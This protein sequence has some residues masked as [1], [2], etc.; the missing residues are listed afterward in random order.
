M[1]KIGIDFGT[2]FCSA[3]WINPGT[4]K[5]EAITFLDTEGDP[6]KMPSIVYYAENGN[7][8]VGQAAYNILEDLSRISEEEEQ[9]NAI[10]ASIFTSI[11]RK[12]AREG[13]R[14][15]RGRDVT[16]QTVIKDILLKIKTEAEK[17]PFHGTIDEAVITHPVVFD[18]W[19]KEMLHSAAVEAGFQHVELFPEPVAAA[20]GHMESTGQWSHGIL[21]YDFGGGTFDVAYIARRHDGSYD[22]PLI[23]EG[24][25][26]CGGDDIDDLLYEELDKCANQRYQR[27]ITPNSY[28]RD[29][30]FLSRC[31]KQK[32][33]MSIAIKNGAPLQPMREILPPPGF[34]RIEMT[35]DK[36]QFE[37]IISPVIEKTI[38]KTQI[39]L[40]RIRANGLPLETAILIGGS[41]RIPMIYD[42]LAEI[43]HPIVPEKVMDVDVAVALGAVSDR[44]KMPSTC[45]CIHCEREIKSTYKYC[46]YC[47]RD[48][49][50]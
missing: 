41:S 7:V 10:L 11:K 21:V 46:C 34:Q 20:I 19:Q 31:R 12:M 45:R 29:I 35:L 3:A 49:K 5:S 47:G 30:A 4:N 38:R 22:V 13:C 48:P 23:P 25:P 50:C 14:H 9:R 26:L 6:R 18:E 16:H 2:S 28:E 36:E 33:N 1:A 42:R 40:D 39:L 44:I 15:I 37:R 27:R 17:T 32:V 43:L 24:D 8:I